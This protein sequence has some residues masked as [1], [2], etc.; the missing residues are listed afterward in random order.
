MLTVGISSYNQ[1]D[2][3]KRAIESALR[4]TA[5]EFQGAFGDRSLVG[6]DRNRNAKLTSE[7]LQHG[8]Q[9]AQFFFL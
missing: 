1:W 6:I 8:D 9:T 4:E 5:T 3:L 7:T 2:Y